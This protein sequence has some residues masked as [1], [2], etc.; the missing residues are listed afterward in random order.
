M[1]PQLGGHFQKAFSVDIVLMFTA[2][3]E[4]PDLK[5]FSLVNSVCNDIADRRLWRNFR[6]A[7][8]DRDPVWKLDGIFSVLTRNPRRAAYVRTLTV[9]CGWAWSTER[10][11]Q[12]RQIALNMLRLE[13]FIFQALPLSGNHATGSEFTPLFRML[14]AQASGF[15]FKL[16]RFSFE[17]YVRPS[18]NLLEFLRTQPQL[19]RLDGLQID[20]RRP[21]SI[22]TDVLHNL[23]HIQ[24]GSIPSA[25]AW[26]EGRPIRTLE[27]TPE[28]HAREP[29][30]WGVPKA[31]RPASSV[32]PV[33]DKL[34]SASQHIV[35]GLTIYYDPTY[36]T[37]AEGDLLIHITRACP[38]L[39]FLRLYGPMSLEK[40]PLL[41]SLPRLELFGC[42][43]PGWLG[44]GEEKIYAWLDLFPS[45][46]KRVELFNSRKV[47]S[48]NDPD[49]KGSAPQVDTLS[50][51]VA[52]LAKPNDAHGGVALYGS[53]V[54]AQ[55]E[56]H[57]EGASPLI[58]TEWHIETVNSLNAELCM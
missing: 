47:C 13:T 4:G 19:E 57:A 35:E 2:Y 32:L 18:S 20:E 58:N 56:S 28:H 24:T 26:I 5:S 50:K 51:N 33:L 42:A 3:L 38:R 8:T 53:E 31:L 14:T 25:I 9:L 15:K 36:A 1:S 6:L 27:L 7:W 39:R 11:G 55:A 12:F 40:I 37:P 23:K 45:H 34:A 29:R 52:P 22:P 43:F 30:R 41:E 48:R 10:L 44:R 49:G 16:R 17:A 21:I 54:G 46:I